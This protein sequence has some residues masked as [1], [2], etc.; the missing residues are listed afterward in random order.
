MGVGIDNITVNNNAPTLSGVIPATGMNN[1]AA[2][3]FTLSGTWFFPTPVINLTGISPNITATI[4]T[5]SGTTIT[6]TF[7]LS[8]AQA[9]LR[10]VELTNPDGQ[11]ASLPSD[12][13]VTNPAPIISSSTLLPGV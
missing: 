4:L 13:N 9:G 1:S 5:Q 2:V 8:G 3:P 6:G 7:N 10:N 12:Y 11:F